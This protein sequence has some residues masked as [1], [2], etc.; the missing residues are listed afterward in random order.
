MK[1]NRF[2]IHFPSQLVKQPII[3]LLAKQYNLAF[4]ILM[5]RIMPNEEGLMVVEL[6]GEDDDYEAGLQYIQD[7]GVHIQLLSRDVRRDDKR[8]TSC[9]ACITICPTGALSITDRKTM[10]VTYEVDKCVACSLCVKTCPPRAMHITLNNI[11]E[12]GIESLM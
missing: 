3:Y 6:S 9:G 4:N 7:Q 2:V 10:E 5:A 11:E 12:L 1:S 8:C